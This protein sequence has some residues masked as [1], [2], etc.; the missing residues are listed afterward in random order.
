MKG[1]IV[2]RELLTLGE[3]FEDLVFLGLERLP[4]PGEEVRTSRFL[5]TSGGGAV[6][7]AVAA[8]RLGL[9]CAIWSG[10]GDDAVA[11]LKADGVVVRN[12]KR[13]DEPHAISA[14]LSTTDNRSF[15]TFNGVNDALEQR[16]LAAAPRMRTRH[17]HFAFFPTD[18]ARWIPILE[19][20]RRR[21]ITTSW[22]F[23]WNERLLEDR[24]FTDLLERLDLLFLNEQEARLY[25]RRRSLSAAL[26][27]WRQSVRPVIVKLGADGSRWISRTVDLHVPAPRTR[28]IDTTG[29]GDAFNGG[30]LY[31]RLHGQSEAAALRLGNRVGALSTRAPG[32]LDGLP[33]ATDIP[34]AWLRSPSS[35]RMSR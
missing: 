18:C 35:P 9:G 8:S 19:R 30:F 2:A 10:L 27:V 26:A 6:I 31:S 4:N 28:V 16:L 15:V 23:G 7:T 24:S 13:R 29:A 14:A 22:D 11:R 21:G 34:A 5:R 32:G 17:A 33:A 20:C 12:L 3:A 1:L 25:S